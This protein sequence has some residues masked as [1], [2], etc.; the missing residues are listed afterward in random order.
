MA[1]VACVAE[2]IA[3]IAESFYKDEMSEG[4]IYG[5]FRNPTLKSS[6]LIVSMEFL[7]EQYLKS[8]STY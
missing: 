6:G 2:T 1:L 3:Q 5:T 8:I 4:Y 7:E